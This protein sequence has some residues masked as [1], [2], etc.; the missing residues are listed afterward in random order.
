MV[1]NKEIIKTSHGKTSA[2]GN[3]AVVYAGEGKSFT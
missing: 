3:N 1:S 2:V